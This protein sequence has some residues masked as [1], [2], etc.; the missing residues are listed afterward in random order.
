MNNSVLHVMNIYTKCL[1][2]T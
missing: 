2:V 1:T